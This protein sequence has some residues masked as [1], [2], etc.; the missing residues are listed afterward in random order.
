MIIFYMLLTL[1]MT[2]ISYRSSFEFFKEKKYFFV[3]LSVA[4]VI[5]F[6][7]L[8][9]LGLE[10]LIL[11]YD[12]TDPTERKIRIAR[13]KKLPIY[14]AGFEDGKK[15]I[16]KEIFLLDSIDIELINNRNVGN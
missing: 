3:T 8:C 11:K 4:T 16:Y 7:F 10:M 1:F 12:M 14:M 13:E 15:E 2:L 9:F 6:C 5:C